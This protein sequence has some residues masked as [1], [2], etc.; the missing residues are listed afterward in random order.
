[1]NPLR[2]DTRAPR[3]PALAVGA[4]AIWIA[5]FEVGPFVH[6]AFHDRLAA[7][8]HDGEEHT[9][10]VG[11]D[12]WRSHASSE[13]THDAPARAGR[14]RSAPRRAHAPTPSHGAHSLAHRGVA[15]FAIPI[16]LPPLP[17]P[18]EAGPLE[19]SRPSRAP[20]LAPRERPRARAPPV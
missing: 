19:A 12:G 3:L 1:M 8:H 14:K 16:G 6:V 17:P 9:H 18:D 2:T 11:A 10:A 5:G 13:H 4:L 20:D 7:H 15:A